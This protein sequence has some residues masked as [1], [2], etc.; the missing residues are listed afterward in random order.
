MLGF[1]HNIFELHRGDSFELPIY[2][3]L[4]EDRFHLDRYTLGKGDKLYVS[5][6]EPNQP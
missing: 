3:N 1:D 2:I 5:I 6:A 4:G